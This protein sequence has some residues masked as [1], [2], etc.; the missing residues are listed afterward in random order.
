MQ[1]MQQKI[2]ETQEVAIGLLVSMQFSANFYA[3]QQQTTF[4]RQTE[5]LVEKDAK[6]FIYFKAVYSLTDDI[7]AYSYV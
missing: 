1:S 5:I 2:L 6:I 7:M 3:V 4:S